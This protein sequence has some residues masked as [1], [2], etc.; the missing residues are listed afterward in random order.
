MK[1][2]YPTPTSS[3]IFVLLL[4]SLLSACGSKQ[5]IHSELPVSHQKEAASIQLLAPP[6]NSQEIS[7][8]MQL[9]HEE[10]KLDIAL[11]ELQRLSTESPSP[12]KE[13]AAF[14]R[15]ELLLKN[16]YPNALHETK[17]LLQQYPNHALAAYAHYWLALW[18]KSQDI[19]NNIE[20]ASSSE[21]ADAILTELS[22]VLQHPRL[23]AELAE[24]A[25]ALG[26]TEAVHASHDYAIPWYLIAAH[27]DIT[28]R[29][30][31]LRTTASNLSLD[32]LLS[33]QHSGLIS[34]QQ[35]MILYSHFSRLQLMSG[36]IE[37]LQNLA[38]ILSEDA[39]YLPL[40]QKIK[41]WASGDTQDIY[42]GVLLP[43]SG[44]YARFGNQALNGMR[45]AMNEQK[46][47]NVHLYI[48][49]TGAGTDATITAYQHLNELGVNWIIGPLLSKHT[50][51]L[52][53]YLKKNLPIISLSKQ[54]NLAEA[55]PALF[56][57]NTAKN[58]QAV[59]MAQNSINQGMQRMAIIYGSK[60]SEADE[61]NAFTHEFIR[62]GGEIT[63]SVM[64]NN[65]GLDQRNILNDLRENSDDE[66]LLQELLSDLAL[67]SPELNLEVHMPVGIDGLYLA[68][69]G[70]QVSELAGQLAYVDIRNIPM[71]GSSR[72]M[73]G[74]LLDDRGRNLSSARFTQSDTSYQDTS[75]FIEQ[76]REIWGQGQPKKL[77]VI[78][79][80]STRIATLLGSR[81]GLQ[82]YHAIQ[83]MHDSEGF[84]NKSGHVYFDSSGIGKKTFRI[85]KIKR[86]KLVPSS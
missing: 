69:S 21:N 34:P 81:L 23:T 73:D 5:P 60:Q 30:E 29:D 16:N 43:L 32:Q 22:K 13:E 24:Q 78:A 18:W 11:Q 80:D 64:L 55:S 17:L 61:A 52:L 54:N 4:T 35:D 12:L 9:A 74:H 63:D 75:N 44:I 53:P 49:D 39:P 27:I 38:S 26:R 8:L 82:G 37:D 1:R 56:I 50:E 58:T 42:I 14:R 72:W 31:W 86:G 46:Q 2:L 10:G 76:Y 85:F 7:E 68:T 77:F 36:N 47:G 25:L 57:H 67:F 6:Q 79:Y 15:I 84:P 66:A 20:L 45:L 62:L 70:K 33:L 40:T 41:R 3:A 48:E 19:E 51:A 65:Q 83:A 71:L 28:H 59:F